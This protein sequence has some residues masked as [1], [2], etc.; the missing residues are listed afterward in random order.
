MNNYNETRKIS[1]KTFENK[2]NSQKVRDWEK[3]NKEAI[4]LYKEMI[5]Y[6]PTDE[7]GFR[8]F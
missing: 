1:S 4:N 5:L 2:N 8:Q 6:F 7:D 3:E